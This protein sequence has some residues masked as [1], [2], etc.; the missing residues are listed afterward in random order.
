MST[1]RVVQTTRYVVL[2]S[3][4][5][6]EGTAT[7]CPSLADA[8]A[9]VWADLTDPERERAV[10]PDRLE[11]ARRDLATLSGE[12][13]EFIRGDDAWKETIYVAPITEDRT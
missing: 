2:V 12:Y 6:G 8:K 9:V 11:E 13:P 4:N 10:P 7:L 5:A 3:D 1:E